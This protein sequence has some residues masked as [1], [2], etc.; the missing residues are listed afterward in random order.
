MK[1]FKQ[2]K[3][4]KSKDIGNKAEDVAASYLRR[5]KYKVIE[6]NWSNRFCEIDIIAKKGSQLIFVEVKY[7]KDSQHGSGFDYI[8][9]SK[10]QQ[11]EY[12]AN[13][14][15]SSNEYSGSYGLAAIELEGSSY[16]VNNFVLI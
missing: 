2:V 15:V 7:R 5:H 6:R 10:L 16:K 8:T 13:Y 4:T 12:A 3:P 9:P 1:L 11:M 14:W